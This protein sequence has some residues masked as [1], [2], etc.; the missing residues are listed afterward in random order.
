MALE[1]IVGANPKPQSTQSTSLRRP[2]ESPASAWQAPATPKLAPAFLSEGGV[3][4]RWAIAFGFGLVHGFGFSFALRQTLQ[5]AGS[6]L[7]TSLLSFN[8]GVELGQ[9]LVLVALIPALDLL[10]KY[11][12][13]ERL[14]TIIV[15]ALVTHT[16]WHWMTER[17]A[18]LRQFR[19]EWPVLD[20]L[21]WA[22]ALRW[23]MLVV[24]AAGLYWLVFGVFKLQER[25]KPSREPAVSA[26][27][28]S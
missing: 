19:F 2:T 10:F 16:A 25:S 21:F 9:L 3:K 14:G 27:E 5:L 12:V 20:A 6:H 7:L 28:I 18:I 11:V 4:R 1:N 13:A 15:S 8:I 24:I 17:A 22:S 26:E 23:M